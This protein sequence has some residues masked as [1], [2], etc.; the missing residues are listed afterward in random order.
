MEQTCTLLGKCAF[1]DLRSAR[2]LALV[3]GAYGNVPAL[4]A[5]LAH[6]CI[7]GCDAFAFLGDMTGCCGHSDEIIALV[8]ANFSILVAGNLEQQAY[9][10]ETDCACNYTDAADGKCSGAAHAY[11]LRSLNAENQA[12]L[13][14]LPEIALVETRMGRLLLC[15][16]SPAQT[17]EFLYESTVED[18]NLENWLE[19]SRAVGLICTHTGLPWTLPLRRDRF[20]LNCGA[21]GKPDHDGDPAVHY[22]IVDLR[23]DLRRRECLSIQRVSYDHVRWARQIAAEGVAEMFIRPL[24]DGK[25]TVGL[26]SLPLA[27]R[28]K[29]DLIMGACD[30]AC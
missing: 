5:C 12:W 8:R 3:G 7:A 2:R 30:R 6:A 23:D 13:G 27:E 17:N 10:G 4:E 11:S 26:A 18:A 16:G 14:T 24:L 1:H 29:R 19:E 25:W 15:H 9:A 28:W 20:A 22:A 21:I